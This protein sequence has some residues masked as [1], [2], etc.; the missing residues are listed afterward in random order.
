[1]E[2]TPNVI[3]SCVDFVLTDL[4]IGG[5]AIPEESVAI[6]FWEKVKA[7]ERMIYNLEV[8]K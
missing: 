5:I 3:G 1:M 7:H 8:M 2:L 6:N 4:K